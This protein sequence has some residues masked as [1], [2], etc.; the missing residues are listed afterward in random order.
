M[1]VVKDG[2]VGAWV[3]LVCLNIRGRGL[4]NYFCPCAHFAADFSLKNVLV[5]ICWIEFPTSRS[6]TSPLFSASLIPQT[7]NSAAEGLVHCQLDQ[8]GIFGI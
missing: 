6:L 8:R 4:R 3:C 1:L 5:N 2:R 7:P